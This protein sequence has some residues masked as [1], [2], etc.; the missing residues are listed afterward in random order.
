MNPTY[1]QTVDDGESTAAA[2]AAVIFTPQEPAARGPEATTIDATTYDQTT[3]IALS[4]F[5]YTSGT[6][7]D[8]GYYLQAIARS[9]DFGRNYDTNQHSDMYY[10]Y[11]DPWG[12][13][14]NFKPREQ[15]AK[16]MV[17]FS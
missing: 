12:N 14:T 4:Q 6:N 7:G 10:K 17:G 15:V 1:Y 9:Y 16:N 2:N 5:I 8:A 11:E 3:L 13:T